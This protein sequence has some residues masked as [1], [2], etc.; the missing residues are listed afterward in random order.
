MAA[1]PRRSAHADSVAH[2]DAVAHTASDDLSM[3]GSGDL[4]M[5]ALAATGSGSLLLARSYYIPSDD[6]S[7]STLT[8]WSWTYDSAVT[9]TAFAAMGDSS[10]AEELLDQLTALQNADGSIDLAF[11]VATGQG[12][13]IFRAGT[14]AWVGLAGAIFDQDFGSS[15]YVSME[16]LAANYLL[17]LQGA[18]GLIRGGP[19]VSWYSTQNNLLA[20]GFLVHLA[21]ELLADGSTAQA[22]IYDDAAG[23]IAAAIDA[24]LIVQSGSTAYFIEGLGDTVQA[25][26]VQALGV[27][28]LQSRGET[29]LA[30]Q[31]LTYAE[32]AFAVGGRSITLSSDPSTY[33]MTYS[34]PG[35]LSGFAPY[36][37]TG[38]PSVLWP[39]GTAE[40][41]LA[42]ATLG[43]STSTLDQGL[44]AFAALTPSQ[45][46]VLLQADQTVTNAGYGVS[47][48]VWPAAA[49]GAWQ[50]LAQAKTTP[51]LFPP[52]GSYASS[53][54]AD[55]PSQY[56][57]L[58]ETSGTIAADSSGNADNGVYQ[59][60]VTLGAPGATADGNTAATFN[61][62]SG[63]VSTSTLWTNPQVFTIE[64]WFKTTSTTGGLIV[65]FGNV[66]VGP[67]GNYDRM[68]YMGTGGQIYFGVA[69]N[70]TIHTTTAYDDGTWHLA[71]ATLS[72]AGM[73]LYIDG[74]LVATNS[75]V[76][77]PQTYNGY[78]RIGDQSL[79]GWSDHGTNFFGGSIDEVAIYP[80]VL[81]AGRI[82]THYLAAR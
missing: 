78:W 16:E 53:V 50:L 5:S 49:A 15:R 59:G 20:Y 1:C 65:G 26:D 17:S 25:L 27:M 46:G 41:R 33:N 74:A 64:A 52:I 77:T 54:L 57:R 28:Y 55:A 79:G 60:G 62:T 68:I 3:A 29:A 37:G 42:A 7:Y 23:R 38:A 35:P 12:E 31:V 30:G 81:S 24:N 58:G 73:A 56:Y 21:N 6:P 2:A 63:Y 22:V 11:N 45:G 75:K 4:R 72:S 14:I 8:N 43:Q 80:T 66:S 48:H 51:A 10:D 36:I 82:A 34:A 47:Y 9:A 13:P 61:G 69:L 32:S 70:Q 39:E 71:D 67:S 40:V 18:N 76:T 44:A 19:D